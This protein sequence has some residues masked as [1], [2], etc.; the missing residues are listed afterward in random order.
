MPNRKNS[1]K[2]RIISYFAWKVPH[3]AISIYIISKQCRT[4]SYLV[5]VCVARFLTLPPF[6]RPSVSCRVCSTTITMKPINMNIFQ[7]RPW[8]LQ[9]STDN[10][11]NSFKDTIRTYP[12]SLEIRGSSFPSPRVVQ[13]YKV[14]FL[15][16]RGIGT[17][18]VSCLH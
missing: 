16:P 11:V 6:F 12:V 15:E 13:P 7:I 10:V 14:V 4:I 5:A 18:V 3:F 9:Y 1:R 17:F 2:I 8:T